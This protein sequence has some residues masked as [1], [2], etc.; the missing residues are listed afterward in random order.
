MVDMGPIDIRLTA[1]GISDVINA[2]KDVEAR[3]KAMED[4][5]S[6]YSKEGSKKRSKNARDEANEKKKSLD[7]EVSDTKT[8]E[9]KKTDELEKESK[10]R[11]RQATVEANAQIAEASRM[12]RAIMSYSNQ[13]STRIVS[14]MKRSFSMASRIAGSIFALGGGLSVANAFSREMNISAAA[15]HAALTTHVPGKPGEAV[16]ASELENKARQTARTYNMHPED[17]LT[18][19]KELMSKSSLGKSVLGLMPQIA[20][21]AIAENT[22]QEPG[23]FLTDLS[24]S[25][26]VLVKQGMK[27]KLVM[28]MLRGMVGQGRA[29]GGTVEFSEI[30]KE[31]PKVTSQAGFFVGQEEGNAL[32]LTSLLQS[33]T[34]V[35]GGNV[36][37]ASIAVQRFTADIIK[38]N[39]KTG[40]SKVESFLGHKVTTKDPI[41]GLEKFEDPFSI[42]PQIFE[43]SGGDIGKLENAGL[44]IRSNKLLTSYWHTYETAEAAK[45]G[46]GAAAVQKSMADEVGAQLGIPEVKKD[47]TAALGTEKAKFEK[48]INDFDEAI[49]TELVPTIMH[50]II[51]ALKE[52]LPMFKGLLHGLASLIKFVAEHPWVSAF[53]GMGALITKAIVGQ[54]MM[55]GLERGIAFA[56]NAIFARVGLPGIVAATTPALIGGRTAAGVVTA[57]GGGLLA[58][59]EIA[60]GVGVAAIGAVSAVKAGLAQSD[61]MVSGKSLAEKDMD[62]AAKMRAGQDVD[63]QEI[64]SLLGGD[65]HLA[66]ANKIIEEDKKKSEFSKILTSMQATLPN[67]LGGEDAQKDI[68]KVAAAYAYKTAIEEQTAKNL[69]ELNKALSDSISGIKAST[70]RVKEILA[71]EKPTMTSGPRTAGGAG[72]PHG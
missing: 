34:G 64:S 37:E 8:S 19:Q 58:G 70:D 33:A 50:E 27:P 66:A 3:V 42:I 12:T 23:E 14:D 9:Q 45:R 60:S 49:R 54:I 63:A 38:R 47:L 53:A 30:A 51:P 20:E 35:T 29:T 68:E 41:T 39:K 22:G 25:A 6:G 2:F 1:S 7:K 5:I 16:P 55:S 32:K 43:K 48:T 62:R 69:Q 46:T 15:Q 40:L 18:A 44:G 52:M 13:L 61:A 65:N 28:E 10:K 67:F 17:V 59:A 21:L 26:G 71:G 72:L 24:R 31:I 11:I 57:A 56:F 36:R 4:R